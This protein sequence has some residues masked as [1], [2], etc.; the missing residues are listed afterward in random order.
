MALLALACVC[1]FRASKT[2]FSRTPTRFVSIENTSLPETFNYSN[3]CIPR[4]FT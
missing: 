2:D 1:D 4:P 3:S